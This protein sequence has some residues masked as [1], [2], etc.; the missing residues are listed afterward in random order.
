MNTDKIKLLEVDLQI[1]AYSGYGNKKANPQ[2]DLD[3][4]YVDDS[5]VVRYSG[6]N[7]RV[8]GSVNTN[9]GAGISRTV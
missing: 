5:G 3:D 4:T 2:D 9:K 6:S 1:F 7:N 8:G